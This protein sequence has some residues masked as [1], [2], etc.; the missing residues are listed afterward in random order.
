[1]KKLSNKR[2]RLRDELQQAYGDWMRS[3][4]PMDLV[5]D[6]PVDISGRRRPATPQWIAYLEAK[7]RLV[8]AYAELPA[9][10]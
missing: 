9:A 8:E 10:A 2:A 4:S 1:M 7:K 3:T 6:G 5:A